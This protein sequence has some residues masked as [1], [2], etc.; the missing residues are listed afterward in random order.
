MI[1]LTLQIL[2]RNLV[3]AVGYQDNCTVEDDLRMI[4]ALHIAERIRAKNKMVLNIRMFAA[5][6]LQC[7]RCVGLAFPADLYI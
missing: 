6:F 2:L 7:I 1:D 4:P 5:E 3:I